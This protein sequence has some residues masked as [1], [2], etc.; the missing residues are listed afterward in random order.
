MVSS[1]NRWNLEQR[2]HPPAAATGFSRAMARGR[3]QSPARHP[4]YEHGSR[5][6]SLVDCSD[7]AVAKP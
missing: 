2:C 3:P 7:T 5:K 4:W 6:P 1:R